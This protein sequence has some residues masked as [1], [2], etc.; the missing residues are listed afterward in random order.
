MKSQILI[1][2][3]LLFNSIITLVPVD[4]SSVQVDSAVVDV[5]DPVGPVSLGF[6]PE[7]IGYQFL[8]DGDV[9]HIW[10]TQD[11]YYFDVDSGIQL[12][13][14]YNEYWTHNVMMLG[15]YSGDTWNLLYR[16]DE[17]SGFN[18]NIDTDGS[19][20]I[21]ITMWKDLSYGSYD[22]RFAI[23]YYL[24]LNDKNLTVIPYIKNLGIE[25]PYNLAFGWELKDIQIDMTEEYDQIYVNNITS[26]SL[27][28]TLDESYVGSDTDGVFYLQNN[29]SGV[30]NRDLYLR[31]NP[32]L[33]YLLRVKSR[34]GQYNAPVTLF[35][36][37]GMLGVGQEKFTKMY[38]Y[39]STQTI[40]PD[41]V[42]HIYQWVNAPGAAP[43]TNNYQEVDEAVA[44]DDTTMLHGWLSSGSSN[45]KEAWTFQ[46]T[47]YDQ[48]WTINSITYYFRCK[49]FSGSSKRVRPI[50]YLD[51]TEYFGT[52]ETPVSIWVT[53]SKSWSTNPSTSLAW[54]WSEIDAAIFGLEGEQQPNSQIYVRCTQAYVEIDYSAFPV[55]TTNAT[56][57]IEETNATMH[58]YVVYNNSEDN[59]T[60]RFEYGTTTGYGSDS[61]NQS[62]NQG[63]EFS[64]DVGGLLPGTL[65][66]YRS[67]INSTSGAY[68]TGDDMT[69]YTKPSGATGLNVTSIQSG[70]SINWTKDAS[71]DNTVIVR[72]ATGVSSF[73]TSETDGTVVYNGSDELH[74]DATVSYGYAYYYSGFSSTGDQY[75]DNYSSDWNY[76]RPAPPTNEQ[77]V[78][79]GYDINISWVNGTGANTTLLRRKTGSSPSSPTDGT[80]LYNDTGTYYV[81]TGININYYYTAWSYN[82]SINLYSDANN[83]AFGGIVINCYDEETND[84][85][86]FDI[87]ISNQD[88]SQSYESRNNTN[89]LNLNV[90]QLPIGDDIKITVGAAS[91]YSAKSEISTWSIDENLTITYIVLSQ[92]PDSKSSTNVTC[93]NTGDDAHS[94]PPFTLDADLVTILP[95]DADN[96]TKVFVNYTHEEYSSRLYYRDINL[97]DFDVLNTYLPPTEDKELYL[98]EVID[99]ALNTVSDAYIDVKRSVNGTFVVVSR[100]L[101][102]AN[103][104]A[105]LDLISDREY[106]FIISKDGYITENASWT[107]GTSIFTHTFKI[108]LETTPIEPDTFG[109]IISFYGN[110]YV[111]NTLR[112][113]FYDL[114]NATTDSHF[115]VYENYNDTL[116]Y[117]GEYNGTTS[118]DINFWINVT[119]ATR[120]HII[121]L[122]MNH[123]TLGEVINYRIVV[124]PVHID[125]EGGTWLENLIV[126]VVGEWDY[127]YVITLIW[128]LPC[129]FL[130]A[131]L[132]AIGHPGTGILGA[133]VYSIWITWNITLPEETKILTFASIA[134]V[135]GF[136]TL[137]LVKG[138]KVIH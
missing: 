44:D 31:W 61:V 55:V 65:Y 133:G 18:K 103:G 52:W 138:K 115:L 24:E 114:D 48:Y 4:N 47:S 74:V 84:S 100:L 30:I 116:T 91:N 126:S 8:D 39:D 6:Y 23:V 46:D 86:E 56:T 49:S 113:T 45:R 32:D 70:L 108:L 58:G 90:S 38:W 35:V 19:T 57:G 14:H 112:V 28:Q 69:F 59:C 104:Q 109:D 15:Y 81:D 54:E 77:G 22:F 129:V 7:G 128:V 122:Y 120:L 9:L 102:D 51:S 64:D 94:Y 107:P 99:E 106:I 111:N 123:T 50:V 33:T 92:I 42:G 136:I 43:S 26:Y 11:N 105:D 101:T 20:Y 34:D 25:I 124:Y 12:T 85:L 82:T 5:I 131:G 37:I 93:I 110:L 118:N 96:F 119:N 83:I 10:N 67:Y 137:F 1:I 36:R 80:Q 121:V 89:P 41:A 72:N 76:S 60:V 127:G 16:T 79:T 62:M 17:L 40:R 87:S 125:R 29:K 75:S 117:M 98:L 63:S 21:N 73:P 130:I 132:A 95:D 53:F 13:N 68:S 3:L 88:G 27:H 2:M 78:L 66:H 97:F 135:T 134:I 71:A